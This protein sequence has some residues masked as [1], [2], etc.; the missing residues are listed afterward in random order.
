MKYF[1]KYNITREDDVIFFPPGCM[2]YMW[3]DA[4]SSYAKPGQWVTSYGAK[5]SGYLILPGKTADEQEWKE[6]GKGLMRDGFLYSFINPAVEAIT[7]DVTVLEN[8]RMPGKYKL[9]SPFRYVS[10]DS[11]DLIINAEDPDFVRIY[12]QNTGIGF[13]SGGEDWGKMWCYSFNSLYNFP[14][15]D[16]LIASGYEDINITL[17]DNTIWIPARAIVFYF[18]KISEVNYYDNE[19][20]VDSYIILPDPSSVESLVDDG[21][22]EVEYYTLQGVRVT[23]PVPG[24]L[25]IERRGSVARKIIYNNR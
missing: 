17:S 5:Y 19:D 3:P 6:L 8:T 7:T 11:E 13:T 14:T 24:D 4:T 16:A 22:A 12:E 25:V 1:A 23:A 9:L 21:A 18:P 15:L 2:M 10:A 20:A